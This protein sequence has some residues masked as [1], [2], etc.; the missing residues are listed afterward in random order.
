MSEGRAI[1]TTRGK[2]VIEEFD[3]GNY[4]TDHDV[5]ALWIGGHIVALG[6][7]Y[8]EPYYEKDVEHLRWKLDPEKVY[9]LTIEEAS[10]G[11]IL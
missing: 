7:G 4:S 6:D 2:P 8:W 1:L 5:P 3:K 11:D 9:I 10:D